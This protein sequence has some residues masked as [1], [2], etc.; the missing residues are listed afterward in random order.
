MI[1]CRSPDC[2]FCGEKSTASIPWL[3]T[4]CHENMQ[5]KYKTSTNSNAGM[6]IG[7]NIGA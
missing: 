1:F 4:S 2:V 3:S 7:Y 6:H 5:P